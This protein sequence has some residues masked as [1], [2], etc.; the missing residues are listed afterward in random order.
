MGRLV[1]QRSRR[2]IDQFSAPVDQTLGAWIEKFRNYCI[3][4]YQALGELIISRAHF[5]HFLDDFTLSHKVA[6][7]G[8]IE[9]L[10]Q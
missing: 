2:K 9:Q 7:R 10:L 6:I 8:E 5:L 4:Q 1:S 3:L